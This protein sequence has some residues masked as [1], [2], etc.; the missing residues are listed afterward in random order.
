MERRRPRFAI[1]V[2]DRRLITRDWAF[3]LENRLREAYGLEGVPLVIDFVPHSRGRASAR[4]RC[5]FAVAVGSST[6]RYKTR[7]GEAPPSSM[8]RPP[9]PRMPQVASPSRAAAGPRSAALRACGP[10]DP[11]P[12]ARARSRATSGIAGSACRS[13]PGAAWACWRSSASSR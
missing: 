2:N 6:S 7:R 4:P 5:A 11:G 12:G 1:Q 10:V 8:P 3:H 13:T 9:R